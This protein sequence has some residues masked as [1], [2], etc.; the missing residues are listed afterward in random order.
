MTAVD[1]AEL[2]RTTYEANSKQ[3]DI[4]PFFCRAAEWDDLPADTKAHYAMVERTVR[5]P[6]LSEI[7]GLKAERDAERFNYDGALSDIDSLLRVL[8]RRI[9]GE[10]DLASA[11][12][13]VR[14]NYPLAAEAIR[15]Q[16]PDS[17]RPDREAVARLVDAWAFEFVPWNDNWKSVV[18]KRQAEA[19]AK[20]D[21]ILA[22]RPQTAESGK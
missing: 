21:A 18:A 12:E 3:F 10:A 11:A 2:G 5:A 4:H 20:A 15:T 8:I 14:L 16:A 13:W 17:W 6:L 7:E 22:L 19:L 9:N 1:H